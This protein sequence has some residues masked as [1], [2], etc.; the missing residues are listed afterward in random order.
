MK[1]IKYHFDKDDSLVF[2][3]IR[4]GNL[5]TGKPL[6]WDQLRELVIKSTR[7]TV[8]RKIESR[9]LQELVDDV[10][11][12]LNKRKVGIDEQKEE[13]KKLKRDL[14]N[15][16]QIIESLQDQIGSQNQELN[17]LRKKYIEATRASTAQRKV[18]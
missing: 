6:S 2:D 17:E 1:K 16:G 7:F 5:I 13:I 15:S 8:G 9:T 3:G 12:F 4:P 14:H 10:T 18:S 11:E